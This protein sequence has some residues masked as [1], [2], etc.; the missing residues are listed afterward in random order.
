MDEPS[1]GLDPES[2]RELWNI[3][4]DMRKDHTIFITTHYMEE[5][6]ALADKI[7]IISHGQL[8]CYG[9]S[10]QLKRRF[11]TGYILKLLTNEQFK[12]VQT[13]DLIQKFVP[14]MAL[15]SF[16]KPT[17][18]ISLPYKYQATFPELLGQLETKQQDLGIS[19]ISI[20]NSSLEDV[21]LKSDA[22]YASRPKDAMDEVDAVYNRLREE[23]L[24]I[25]GFEQFLAIWYKKGIFMRAHWIYW[26]LLVRFFILK[27]NIH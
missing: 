16:V 9:P 25:S 2:R 27:I 17:L 10:I 12:Q 24:R 21:F 26:I 19:S 5:A 11:E 18:I 14:D 7:A 4:L 6:E 3:L 22:S 8:L 13:V 23:P 15:K 1:S 20:T